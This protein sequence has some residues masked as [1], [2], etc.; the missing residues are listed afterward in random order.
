MVSRSDVLLLLLLI[1]LS[2]E[3]DDI[4]VLGRGPLIRVFS[5]RSCR[6]GSTHPGTDVKLEIYTL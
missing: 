4:R 6:S 1:R 5:Q 2:G 3:C